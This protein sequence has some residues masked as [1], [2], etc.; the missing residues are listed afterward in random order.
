MSEISVRDQI[1]KLIELQKVDSEIYR[2]RR[3][4]EEKPTI[5][6][7]LE[8]DFEEAKKGLA[9][10]EEKIKQ[11]KLARKDKELEL[12]AKEEEI[13]KANTQLSQLKTN[14]EYTAKVKEIEGMKAD[15]SIIEEKILL[16]YEEADA[17]EAEIEREKQRVA[18]EEKRFLENKRAIEEEIK[19]CEK[20]IHELSVKR[21][22]LASGVDEE[23]LASYEK[24]LPKKNGLAIVKVDG[25][26]CG[27]CY[28][29]VTPQNINA[30]KMWN[31]LVRCDHC[32][33]IL[34]IEEDDG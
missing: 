22:Q 29:N 6:E 13:A 12:K 17:V 5:I 9:V 15:V 33:R 10:L 14:K 2:H 21:E 26:S 18:A 20:R 23:F 24:L 1:R 8:Q 7:Q 34:Y 25:T 27:G 19:Q 31:Q 4:L 16:S 28:M 32:L 11:I 30:I 3:E